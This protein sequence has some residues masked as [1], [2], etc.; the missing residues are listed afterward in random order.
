[1]SDQ[2]SLRSAC[3]YAQS[4]QSLCLLLEYSMNQLLTEHNLEFLS[5]KGG[6]T[7][8]SETT[9]VKMPHCHGSITVNSEIFARVYFRETSHMR[10]FAK[11]KP[12]RKSENSLSLSDEGKSYRS[13][14]F[15]RGKYAFNTTRENKILAKISELKYY[16]YKQCI[17]FVEYMIDD[18]IRCFWGIVAIFW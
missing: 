12:S 9:L 13:R 15:L 11:I 2:Q 6:C 5:F 16:T 7:G 10:S 14:E 17:S 1:M 8:S 18:L 3:A 4:D